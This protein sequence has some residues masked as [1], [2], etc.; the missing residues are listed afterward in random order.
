M[1]ENIRIFLTP[2]KGKFCHTLVRKRSVLDRNFKYNKEIYIPIG[3]F[4]LDSGLWNTE[5]GKSILYADF[6][7]K[8]FEN[9]I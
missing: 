9:T 4:E 8:A 3:D 5:E 2:V 7:K 1:A 6:E